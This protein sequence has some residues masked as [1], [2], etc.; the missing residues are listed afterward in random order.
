MENKKSITLLAVLLIA[1]LCVT[2]FLGYRVYD[3][4]HRDDHDTVQYVMYI[5]L[6][7]KDTYEQIIP[8]E[9]AKAI[10]DE[11]CFRYLDGYTI[12]DAQGSWVDEKGNATHEQTIV[13]YFNGADESAVANIAD[14]ILV[15]LNQNTV[16]IEKD[17]I[18]MTYYGGTE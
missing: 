14:E 12:Q 8:T 13:C 3:L 6:N 4:S 1:N 16:L 17:E 10:V 2:A 7:D 9:E 18:S 11:I 5:G 15:R